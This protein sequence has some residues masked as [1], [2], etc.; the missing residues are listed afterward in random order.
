VG[1]LISLCFIVVQIGYSSWHAENQ[2][3][4]LHPSDSAYDKAIQ[5]AFDG[6]AKLG[7]FNDDKSGVHQAWVRF[8]TSRPGHNAIMFYS[9]LHCAQRFAD[10]ARQKKEQRPTVTS[11]RN[12]C[13]GYLFAELNY[14]AGARANSFPVKIKH[15]EIEVSPQSDKLTVEPV[16]DRHQTT[17]FQTEYTY[18]YRGQLFVFKLL[19]AWTY[20]VTVQYVVPETRDVTEVPLDLSV[21]AEDEADYGSG[22]ASR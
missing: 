2:H 9:P 5:E 3:S 15:K 7:P 18:S 21:F 8:D 1:L 16:V 20:G 17:S 14:T 13:D 10:E 12:E 22:V 19:D 6:T 11:I 4:W